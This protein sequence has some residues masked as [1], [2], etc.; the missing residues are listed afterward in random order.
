MGKPVIGI[1][2]DLIDHN[3]LLRAAAPMNYVNAVA[4]A[5]G[6][7]VVVPPHPQTTIALL[8]RLDGV[9]LTGGDDPATDP[10]GVPTDPRATRVSPQRQAAESLLL[11]HLAEHRLDMPV[12]G[13]CLGMQMMALHAGGE[14]DQYMPD[15]TPTH[16]DHWEN[17]H[18]VRSIDEELLA[19]GVV[20][21]KHK[22]AVA[23][24]GTLRVIAEAHDGVCEAI[25]DPDRHFYLGVQWHPERTE[26]ETLGIKLFRQMTFACGT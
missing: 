1:T 15:T 24:P 8:E 3:G 2:A 23:K 12:L 22:Q 16:A 10:F 19:S 11:E 7:P 14:L 26:Q 20:N 17:R 4:N 13:V 18:A 25:V 5:G 6:V 9:V 21:S